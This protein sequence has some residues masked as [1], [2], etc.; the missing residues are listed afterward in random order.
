MKNRIKKQYWFLELEERWFILL[1]VLCF[2]VSN[3]FF[4]HYSLIQ[5][6]SAFGFSSIL[7]L[8]FYNYFDKHK[9]ESFW[10]VCFI[11]V[12]WTVC[13]FVF[14]YKAEEKIWISLEWQFKECSREL[15]CKPEEVTISYNS[16]YCW[17]DWMSIK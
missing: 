12:W 6:L 2:S 8:L 13:F 17:K 14:L 16:C 11:I 7:I 10:R 3:F 1:W 5:S 9:I 4:Q 15:K